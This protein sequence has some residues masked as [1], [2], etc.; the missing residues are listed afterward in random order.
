L[1]LAVALI[2]ACKGAR[3]QD[4]A[5]VARSNELFERAKQHRAAGN[6]AAACELFA[7]SHALAPRGGTLLNLG[8]CHESLGQLTLARSELVSA[9]AVARKDGRAERE[10]ISRQH[11]AAIE[12]RLAW[13][14]VLPPPNVAQAAL[15]M[16]LD[17]T[18]LD[19]NDLSAIPIEPGEHYVTVDSEGFR[20][21]VT[22]VA[23]SQGAQLKVRLAPLES[24]PAPVAAQIAQVDEPA[25]LP[26]RAL[27]PAPVEPPSRPVA[28]GTIRTGV[29]VVSLVAIATS[30]TMGGLAIAAMSRVSKHCD[31]KLCDAAGVSAAKQGAAFETAANVAAAVGGVG[32]VAWVAIPGGWL[33][34]EQ[35]PTAAFGV[36]VSGRL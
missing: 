6:I 29:L 4:D 11:I 3:A 7:Q 20:E 13:L 2:L 10:E 34:P 14:T 12:A 23:V 26:V 9:L 35:P 33:N 32:L 19:V 30:L 15:R 24:S 16:R 21:Q 36:T 22:R 1:S 8:L 18:T 25:P 5:L 17:D 31:G 27:V 28:W